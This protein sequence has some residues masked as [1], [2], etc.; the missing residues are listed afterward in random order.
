MVC[1][2]IVGVEAYD[3]EVGVVIGVFWAPKLGFS[4]FFAV[5]THDIGGVSDGFRGSDE[6]FVV[7]G[8]CW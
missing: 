5:W 6:P 3:T 2:L 7:D 1:G 8:V 4:P